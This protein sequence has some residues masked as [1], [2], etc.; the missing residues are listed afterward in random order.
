MVILGVGQVRN[1]NGEFLFRRQRVEELA[2]CG[3]APEWRRLTSRL[4]TNPAGR[5]PC[6]HFANSL[7]GK[8]VIAASA[9]ANAA[10]LML[11]LWPSARQRATIT[12]AARSAVAGRC[13]IGNLRKARGISRAELARLVNVTSTAVWNWEVNGTIPRVETLASAAQ[14]LGVS[15]SHLRTGT[16][17]AVVAHTSSLAAIID[18]ATNEI[19]AS[20]GVPRSRVKLHVEFVP[21]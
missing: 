20:T 14:V 4:Q 18:R 7:S 6:H 11:A 2:K 12:P 1:P 19:A 21:S 5:L 17:D 3:V 9:S 13:R 16:E 8:Y 15:E 10:S